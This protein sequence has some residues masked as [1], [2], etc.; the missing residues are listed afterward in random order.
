MLHFLAKDDMG[1][2]RYGRRQGRR[3]SP[4]SLIGQIAA[5]S[6]ALALAAWTMVP[7]QVLAAGGALVL[8]AALAVAAW[9]IWRWHAK[10]QATLGE[11]ERTEAEQADESTRVLPLDSESIAAALNG[12]SDTAPASRRSPVARPRPTNAA[13]VSAPMPRQRSG[14]PT[15]AE[16]LEAI[17]WFQFERLMARVY[18][19]LGYV[20]DRRGGA[21]A[22]DG[23]DLVIRKDGEPLG[24]QCKHW[25]AWKVNPKTVR[26]MLGAITAAKLRSGII[27]CWRG[28]T[29]D[30]HTKAAEYGI[31]LVDASGILRMLESVDARF[32]PELQAL[33]D[34]RRKFCPRCEAEMVERKAT[35]G[36]NAGGS[37]WGCSRYPR[38][39][40]TLDGNPSNSD[41]HS[42]AAVGKRG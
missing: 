3:R 22:D 36:E 10:R 19:K 4:E 24:V 23:I 13:P 37:F 29:Q 33:L 38:C 6:M 42:A 1:Y 32:D 11:D 9:L 40:Y 31:T 17:D 34:D 12:H 21:H 25:K 5:L 39:D 7:K 27:L 28:F 16:K 41:G 20:V 30:G 26:E 8:L 35:K 14:E 15:I 2:R 18:E